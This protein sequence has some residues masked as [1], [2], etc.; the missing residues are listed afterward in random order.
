MC[1]ETSLS[2][3]PPPWAANPTHRLVAR[4]SSLGP[5]QG[6]PSR[7]RQPWAGQRPGYTAPGASVP[8]PAHTLLDCLPA[9]N[10]LSVQLL[11]CTPTPATPE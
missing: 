10:H 5:R 4:L 1:Y 9:Q 3:P 7:L 8:P 6:R 11:G 2:P